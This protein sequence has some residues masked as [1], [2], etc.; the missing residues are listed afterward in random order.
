MIFKFKRYATT[1]EIELLFGYEVTKKSK[2]RYIVE[3]SKLCISELK[4]AWKK[5]C[6]TRNVKNSISDRS[7]KVFDSFE[8]FFSL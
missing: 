1:C 2:G 6:S 3:I 4:E 8:Q 7:I 5:F